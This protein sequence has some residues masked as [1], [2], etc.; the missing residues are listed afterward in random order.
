MKQSKLSKETLDLISSRVEKNGKRD[1]VEYRNLAKIINKAMR[2]D[3]RKFKVQLA[4]NT[5][6]ANCN[7][8]VLRS[9]LMNAK[10][11]IFK[12]RDKNGTI[13]SDRNNILNIAKG[14]YEELFLS[15]RP[16]PT[17]TTEQTHRDRLIITNVGSE[18]LP[19]ITEE[20]VNS[21]ETWSILD[22]LNECRVDSRYSNIIRYENATSCKKL[23]ENT[24]KFRSVEV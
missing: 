5:I 1:S 10:K 8:K 7:M 20:E 4:R 16:A 23:H 15:V 21:V 3:L 14:F 18:E 13:Q 6:E 9:K 19:D 22:S 24:K 11:E 12:L 17:T 2:S